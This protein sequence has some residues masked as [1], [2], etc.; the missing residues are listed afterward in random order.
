MRQVT[1]KTKKKH[2]C[3]SVEWHCET[4]SENVFQ[5]PAQSPLLKTLEFEYLH[6]DLNLVTTFMETIV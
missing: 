1:K 2:K 3:R 4:I 6:K 5:K